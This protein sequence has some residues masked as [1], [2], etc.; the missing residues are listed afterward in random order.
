MNNKELK[1]KI[2]NYGGIIILYLVIFIGIVAISSR[3]QYINK[4]NENLI[5][6]QK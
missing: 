5:A 6:I 2:K 3:L 1:L 4:E